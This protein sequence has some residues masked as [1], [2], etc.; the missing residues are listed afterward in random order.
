MKKWFF[1]AAVALTAM[2]LHAET[3]LQF[4]AEAFGNVGTGDLAPYYMMSNNGG[5][6]TQGKTAA[7]RAKA[8]KDFDLSKRFSY[9][10]G[11]DALTGYALSTD[12]MHCFPTEDGKGEMVPVA[13]RPSA[14]WLQQLYGAVKYRGVFLS[15]GMKELNSPLLNTELGSGDYIQSN[16]A[17]PMP[18]LRAGFV[19]FQDIPFTNGWVQIQ[20]EIMYGKYIDGNWLE[21]HYNYKQHFI[22]TG[23]WAHY[24]RMYFR[25]KPEKPF[26]VTVGM[27]VMGQYCGNAKTYKNGVLVKE[28]P[29]DVGFDE[30][31][32]MF[33]P[34]AGGSNFGD[35]QYVFGNTL[36]SWDFV[37][38]YRL[39]DKTELKAYFQWPYEDGTGIGKMNGFDGI[40]G[41]EYQNKD[42]KGIVS[43]AVIEYIDFMH[44]S[45][46]THWAPNDHPGTEMTDHATGGDNYYNNFRYNSYMYYGMS[47]GTPFIPSIIYNTDGY[48][49]VVHN[50]IRGFHAGVS[51][52]IYSPLK[53]RVLVSYRKSLGTYGAP[54]L[55]P[56]HDTSFMVEGTYSFPQVKGLDLKGQLA[57]DRGNLLGNNFGVMFSLSYNGLFNVF[58]K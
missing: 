52:Y 34:G 45:G 58:G 26:S 48:M 36:G 30:F 42:P 28:D 44:Q 18:E 35:S 9:S 12:Y 31:L 56:L 20:G 23:I 55:D 43:G 4:R 15:F 27:Q 47:K 54:L 7:V 40:W 22:N 38:R 29:Y 53:Y 24:K 17:R 51:G 57:V 8:W 14:A 3:P 25:T 39:K 46:P 33:I 37:A 49:A 41:L 19:D 16:N 13:R 2:G 5:V 11:V 6:L 32:N 21:E 50:R 1:L 10:F